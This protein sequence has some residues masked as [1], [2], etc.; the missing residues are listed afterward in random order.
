M[1]TQERGQAYRQ[2][3]RQMH[4]L[5]PTIYLRSEPVTRVLLI[6][7]LHLAQLIA[8]LQLRVYNKQ[9]AISVMREGVRVAF[10]VQFMENVMFT[11]A[12]S[13]MAN[14]M[15]LHAKGN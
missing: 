15:P 13:A 12:A 7:A 14:T 9:T 8:C 2:F 3:T 4:H 10:L 5:T 11:C 6:I 1:S